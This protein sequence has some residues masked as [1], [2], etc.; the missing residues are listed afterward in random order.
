MPFDP[1]RLVFIK[2]SAEPPPPPPGK[3]E[4]R[5]GLSARFVVTAPLIFLVKTPPIPAVFCVLAALP[6]LP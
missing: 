3:P 2:P 4:D 1:A 5:A 6:P